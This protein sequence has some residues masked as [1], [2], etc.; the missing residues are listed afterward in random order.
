M[1]IGEHHHDKKY[2]TVPDYRAFWPKGLGR[3]H[4]FVPVTTM[5]TC[6]PAAPGTD[7][8]LAPT[9]HG[10]F[11]PIPSSRLGGVSLDLMLAGF[12]RGNKPNLEQRRQPQASLVGRDSASTTPRPQQTVG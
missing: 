4:R 5:S 10:C 6:R 9:E 8:P 7:Q 3:G 1:Q 2:Q 11:G 12:A